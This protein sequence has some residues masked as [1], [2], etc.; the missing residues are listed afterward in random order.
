MEFPNEFPREN[1]CKIRKKSTK[2]PRKSVKKSAKKSLKNRSPVVSG[3]GT[4][5]I[6]L[7]HRGG[8][9]HQIPETER[10]R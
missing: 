1:P 6:G 4:M 7:G 2:S 3:F 8:T 9:Q 10:G 5:G